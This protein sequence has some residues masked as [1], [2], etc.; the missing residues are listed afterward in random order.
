[1]S[2]QVLT[3]EKLKEVLENYP[4]KSYVDEKF[5]KV[6]EKFDKVMETLVDIVGQLETIREDQVLA[7]GKDKEFEFTLDNHEKRI[8]KLEQ[9]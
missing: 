2:S 1:M 5:D 4:T 6:D 8:N 7:L 9:S 3:E